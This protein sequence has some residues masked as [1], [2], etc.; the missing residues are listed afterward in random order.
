METL[1][2]KCIYKVGGSSGYCL[3]TK[4]FNLSLLTVLQVHSAVLS[5]NHVATID[6]YAVPGG[7]A[8]L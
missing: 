4:L 2:G 7:N 3:K 1:I 5:Y 8:V 6:M